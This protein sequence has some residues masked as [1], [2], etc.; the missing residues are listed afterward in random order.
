[1]NTDLDDAIMRLLAVVRAGRVA[2]SGAIICACRNRNAVAAAMEPPCW[3][4]DMAA[5]ADTV[6][7]ELRYSTHTP[8]A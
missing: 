8:G 7:R 6:E 2:P 5:A 3:Y 4:C 1:M